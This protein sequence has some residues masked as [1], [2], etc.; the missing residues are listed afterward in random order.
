MS[1]L[2]CK[3]YS[4]LR[5][6]RAVWGEAGGCPH[7]LCCLRSVAVIEQTNLSGVDHTARP[8]LSSPAG[9]LMWDQ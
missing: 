4:T 7:A 5:E 6:R 8:S 9:V 2:L 1:I 3:L